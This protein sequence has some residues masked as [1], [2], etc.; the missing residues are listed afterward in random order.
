MADRDILAQSKL[1]DRGELHG[2]MLSLHR[3]AMRRR[4]RSVGNDAIAEANSYLLIENDKEG[5]VTDATSLETPISEERLLL[6][7]LTHRVKN[8]FASAIGIVSLAASRSSNDE[9]KVALAAVE[10]CLH[11]HAQVHRLLE[12]PSHQT[13]MEASEHIPGYADRLVAPSWIPGGSSSCLSSALSRWT[14]RAAG[15]WA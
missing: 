3:S 12:M 4:S 6:R 7:E 2:Q 14:R 1:I 8:E 9:V 15:V 5:V 13:L 10:Q 11:N